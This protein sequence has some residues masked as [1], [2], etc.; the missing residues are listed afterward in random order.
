MR[1]VRSAAAIAGLLMV[2]GGLAACGNVV[3]GTGGRTRRSPG[4]RS[5][6]TTASTSRPPARWSR[7]SPSRPASR[8]RCAATTRTSSPSRSSRRVR[9]RRPTSST[10]R[11]ARRWPV[12]TRPSLLSPVDASTL[13]A[14]PA[15]YNAGD[16]NWVGVSAR[17]SLHRLQHRQAQGVRAA[18]VDPRPGRPEVEGQARHR[19]GRDRLRADRHLDRG[20]PR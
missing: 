14:V 8:S 12:S 4:R 18:H 5:R 9:I 15:A 20:Q 16:H 7:P 6:S 2:A 10:P 17:V 1:R 11:T 3:R 13:A 19:P